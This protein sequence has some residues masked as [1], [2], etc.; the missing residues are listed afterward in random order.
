MRRIAPEFRSGNPNPFRRSIRAI[1]EDLGVG[2]SSAPRDRIAGVDRERLL[3][4]RM[5]LTID[6]DEASEI[7]SE[8]EDSG[9]FSPQEE[10]DGRGWSN[11]CYSEE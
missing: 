9:Y 8:L 10:D 6:P 7:L 5:M 2:N 11:R 3:L 4:A 1:N